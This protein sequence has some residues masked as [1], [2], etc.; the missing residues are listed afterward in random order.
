[1]SKFVVKHLFTKPKLNPTIP[2]AY[3]LPS[4]EVDTAYTLPSFA[5]QFYL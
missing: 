4:V 3:A 1:M 5:K 2:P